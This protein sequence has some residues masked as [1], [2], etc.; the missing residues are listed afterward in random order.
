MT[1][2]FDAKSTADEVLAGVDLRGKRYLVTGTSAG[3]GVETARALVARGASVVGAVRDLAK[4]R[5]ATAPARDATSQAGGSFEWS[6]SI[7]RR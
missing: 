6:R 5:N 4:A 7:S 2:K 1:R 3:I